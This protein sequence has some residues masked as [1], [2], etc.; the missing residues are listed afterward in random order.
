MAGQSEDFRPGVGSENGVF[1]MGGER[2]IGGGDSPTVRKS[3]G[4]MASGVDHRLDCQ[5]HSR[6]NSI[7]RTTSP[8]VWDFRG[9]VHASTNTV[10][11][12]FANDAET[13]VFNVTLDGVGNIA[14]AIAHDGRPDA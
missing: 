1:E 7:P 5:G 9:L 10:S 6:K 3:P 13:V 2:A 14:D 8:E 4:T 11:H 12:H